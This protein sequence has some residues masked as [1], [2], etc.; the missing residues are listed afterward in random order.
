MEGKL[1]DNVDLIEKKYFTLKDQINKLTKIMEDERNNRNI[2][3]KQHN[4]EFNNLENKIKNIFIEDQK[5][6]QIFADDL[7]NKIESKLSRFDK[8]YKYENELIKSYMEK[9]KE[10]FEV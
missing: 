8:D 9:I 3:K 10:N 1:N 4:E 2:S 6:M 7:I 5:N